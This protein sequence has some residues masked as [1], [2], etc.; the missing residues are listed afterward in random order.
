MKHLKLY[1]E[2]YK[3][4]EDHS[5]KFFN[6][7]FDKS[8][9]MFGNIVDPWEPKSKYKPKVGNY[10]I[11]EEGM[12]GGNPNNVS[13]PYIELNNFLINNIGKIIKNEDNPLIKVKYENIP[14]EL[15]HH[16][17]NNTIKTCRDDIIYWS[18]NKEELETILT[19]KKYNI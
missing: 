11:C 19:L 9:Y 16:F 8:L 1:E 6:K 4:K 13:R 17:H 18:K 7:K 10:V 15:N 3:N 2:K 5:L 12:I 14:S